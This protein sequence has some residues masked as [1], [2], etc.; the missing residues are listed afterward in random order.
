MALKVN[1]SLIEL[2]KRAQAGPPGGGPPPGPPPGGGPGGP[3]PG[4]P[5]GGP[6]GP[7]PGPPG[8]GPGGPPPGPPGGG[9]PGM[10]PPDMMGGPPPDMPLPP[11]EKEEDKEKKSETTAEEVKQIVKDVLSELGISPQGKTGKPAKPDLGLMANDIYQVKKL[12]IHL[13]RVLNIGI[14][15][16]ALE[17]PDLRASQEQP[18][19]RKEEEPPKSAIPPIEPIEPAVKQSSAAIDQLR[20]KAASLLIRL[21]SSKK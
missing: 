3:P 5:G 7:P 20:K 4:P 6:G 10:P 19:E 12:M 13:F 2:I 11:P 9:P 14:P 8:G 15:P 16:D 21:K 1:K 18:P 17:N